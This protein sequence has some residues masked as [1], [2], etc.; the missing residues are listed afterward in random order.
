MY[1]IFGNCGY[2]GRGVGVDFGEIVGKLRTVYALGMS[3]QYRFWGKCMKS[4]ANVS[5]R[6][7]VVMVSISENC[8]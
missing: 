6:G 5:I 3:Q 8:R 4:L 2:L 1:E 7:V